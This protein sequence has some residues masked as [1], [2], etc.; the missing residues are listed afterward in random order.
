MGSLRLEPLYGDDPLEMDKYRKV[1]QDVVKD[2]NE[3]NFYWNL[4]ENDNKKEEKLRLQK[5]ADDLAV[6][7]NIKVLRKSKKFLL[8]ILKERQLRP[9]ENDQTK[10]VRHLTEINRPLNRR[11]I[12]LATQI[13]EKSWRSAIK[14]LIE[15][16]AILTHGKTRNLTFRI[17]GVDAPGVT[18]SR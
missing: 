18:V 8:S 10:I 5:A 15:C 4:E 16:G 11:E 17:P 12:L 9:V 1:V 2:H 13:P 6:C 14:S 3:F 7:L